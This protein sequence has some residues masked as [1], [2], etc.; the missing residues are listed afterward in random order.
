MSKLSQLEIDVGQMIEDHLMLLDDLPTK[1]LDPIRDAILH[2]LK[3][4]LR[5][6]ETLQ[7]YC[8]GDHVYPTECLDYQDAKD[9]L[10]KLN[11]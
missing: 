2:D 8:D 4:L 1:Q 10:R 5:A 9:W 6:A 7:Q 11:Q 3:P